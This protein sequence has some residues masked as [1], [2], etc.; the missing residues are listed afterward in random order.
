MKKLLYIALILSLVTA[1]SDDDSFS[2]SPHHL[3][4]FE[5]DTLSL[6]TI[7]ST[8]A[9]PNRQAMVYN[10]SGDGIR[11]SDVRLES[12]SRSP[13][14]VNVNGT[15]ITSSPNDPVDNLELR[16]GDSIRVFV[17]VT[18]RNNGDTLPKLVSDNLVFTLESNVVQKLALN[19]WSWD[20]DLLRKARFSKDTTIANV[21]GRPIV[22]YDTLTVDSGVTLSVAPSTTLYFHDGAG[23]NVKGTLKLNGEKDREVTLRSDRLDRMVSNLTYDNNPG[24]WGGIRFANSSYGNEIHY[25][26]IHSGTNAILCDSSD[27][28]N[29]KITIDHSTIHNMEGYGIMAQNCEIKMENT[30][31]SN[32]RR[33]C[34]AFLGGK[35]DLNHCTIVQYYPFDAN[36]GAALY[37][38]H[39]ADTMSYPLHLNVKNSIIKGYADD[40]I[41]W[42]ENKEGDTLRAEFS[43]SILRTFTDK[44]YEYM[45][46]DCVLEEPTDTLLQGASFFELFDTNNFFYNFKPKRTLGSTEIVNPA[47][48]H[49]N[50]ETTLPDDRNGLP[51]REEGNHDAGCYEQEER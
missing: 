23:M 27:T 42:T 45:F 30:L 50:S 29:P 12:G 49:A 1:C 2:T 37:F 18:T 22:I 46:K 26:D 8:I 40:V 35:I 21:N 33:G 41:S 20:A 31:V 4:T 7:F 43:N 44:D 39:R 38:A 17:E 19:V 5:K 32:A 9:S 16:N 6:D 34:L 10:N 51:R 15:Y 13:F 28:N 36:R 25:T 14:R 24:Q 48:N 47:I 11:I 3:L